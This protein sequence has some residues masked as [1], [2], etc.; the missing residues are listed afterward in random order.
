MDF[1]RREIGASGNRVDALAQVRFYVDLG[2]HDTS[3]HDA[4]RLG[5]GEVILDFARCSFHIH[6]DL[7]PEDTK[8]LPRSAPDAICDPGETN[9]STGFT[10]PVQPAC[11]FGTLIL[12][13]R[14]A[15]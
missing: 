2:S 13:V 6:V 8:C 15:Q 9:R 4:V 11:E 1:G 10:L 5:A 3:I 7:R 14:S 12:S